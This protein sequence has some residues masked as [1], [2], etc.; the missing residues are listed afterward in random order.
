[1]F[2]LRLASQR[3]AVVRSLSAVALAVH[4]ALAVFRAESPHM[5]PFHSRYVH[6][7]ILWEQNSSIRELLVGQKLPTLQQT[8]TGYPYQV[9]LTPGTFLPHEARQC[10]AR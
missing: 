7:R 5:A 4:P 1:M 9:S 2:E 10:F 6:V 3:V 8:A